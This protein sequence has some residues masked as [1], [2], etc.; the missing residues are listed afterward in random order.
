MNRNGVLIILLII[1]HFTNLVMTVRH[2]HDIHNKSFVKDFEKDV[3][4][5]IKVITNKTKND[6]DY[7]IDITTK[8]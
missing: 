7:T 4:S 2:S 5:L 3:F 1:N 6:K 8:L